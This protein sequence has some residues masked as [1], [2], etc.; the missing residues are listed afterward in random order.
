MVS[1]TR[2][3]P[4]LDRRKSALHVVLVRLFCS[5]LRELGYDT[6]PMLAEAGIHPA[7][8]D[9]PHG[10][11]SLE[12][13]VALF[14]IAMA[15]TQRVDL[16][17]EVAAR[18][19]LTLF[20]PLGV[21]VSTAPTVR[22]ALHR[23]ISYSR[24]YN[25]VTRYELRED[26]DGGHLIFHELMHMGAAR[27]LIL[28]AALPVQMRVLESLGANLANIHIEIPGPAPHWGDVYSQFFRGRL[29]SCHS[30]AA[31]HIPQRELDKRC[32]A[33]DPVAHQVACEKCDMLLRD[34]VGVDT[35]CRV[36]DALRATGLD[37]AT[38][39]SI[40]S[41]LAMS[42]RTLARQ[43]AREGRTYQ[44]VVDDHRKE[45]ALSWLKST[46]K[47]LSTI[48]LELGFTETSNFSRTFRRW[49]GETPS[50]FRKLLRSD[51]YSAGMN[52]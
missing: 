4:H 25:R 32:V 23:W 8:L 29:V 13:S 20:G 30:E 3:N 48:A 7:S 35:T 6:E 31:I 28:D 34:Y 40:A 1:L 42:P 43:L 17:L 27:R 47:S 49:F 5:V 16:G 19:D 22:D 46:D 21:A 51:E 11:L 15:R 33:A 44:N 50:V 45:L 14:Q 24:I 2:T 39:E 18:F 37:R 38:L 12:Q 26:A 52:G 41:G 10:M 9:Q 36:R